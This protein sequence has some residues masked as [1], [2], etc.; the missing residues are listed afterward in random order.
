[1]RWT[2]TAFAGCLL[3]AGCK[4]A[5][6][7]AVAV[8]ATA[9]IERVTTGIDVTDDTRFLAY[10][11]QRRIPISGGDPVVR[12]VD[13]TVLRDSKSVVS[14][15][16]R[17]VVLRSVDSTF[18]PNDTNRVVD[19]FVRD[20]ATGE[21]ERVSVSSDGAEADGLSEHHGISGD[22]RFVAFSSDATNLV[23]NDGNGFAD[24]FIR[25]RKT[26]K[27]ELVTRAYDGS[28]A[29]GPSAY[30]P[31]SDDGRYVAFASEATNLVP[32]DTNGVT[33]VFI[34]DRRLRQTR[35]ISVGAG[36]VQADGASTYP[37]LSATGRYVVFTSSATNLVEGDTN[38]VDD[39]FEYDT[40][41]N[42]LVRVSV[43]SDGTQSDSPSYNYTN[44]VTRD[45][46]TIAFVSR[47]TLDAS[48][49]NG[50]FDVYVR[51]RGTSLTTLISRTP[52]GTS[53][54]GDSMHATVSARDG[55]Y[56]AFHSVASDLTSDD[57]NDVPD[58][59]VYDRQASS[60][61]RISVGANHGQANLG[62][63]RASI[64]SSGREITFSSDAS[65]LVPG[66]SNQQTDV[67]IYRFRSR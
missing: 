48:D 64:S 45:G 5:S 9:T 44:A 3:L 50:T 14:S 32:N 30:P 37:S 52:G 35:R 2:I 66:D 27:T 60:M 12:V 46:R 16:G 7:G 28:D 33:D 8:D 49:H 29:N 65:N 21:M 67:F 15:N 61:K 4:S 47:S 62:S 54:S 39:V 25:D 59:F 57:T 6:T 55:R 38:G 34:Y 53:G 1:M 20:T 40:N 58:V 22:G 26:K 17:F 42:A 63:Y 19:I 23:S 31:I 51:D 41:T 43:K 11:V 36:G 56:V 10:N 24:I 13:R 18:V